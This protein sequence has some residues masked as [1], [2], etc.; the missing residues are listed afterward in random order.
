M[1]NPSIDTGQPALAQDV[2]GRRARTQGLRTVAAYGGAVLMTPYLLI[3]IFW[4]VGAVLG[5]VTPSDGMSLTGWLTLNLATIVMAAAGIALALALAEFRGF[6][7]PAF[8]VLAFAWISC[9][10]LV[11]MLP[12]LA[13]S[14]ALAGHST[15]QSA[16]TTS[17]AAPGWEMILIQ[18]SFAGLGLGLAIALPLYLLNRWPRA[19]LGRL[20]E[21]AGSPRR[22]G[23]VATVAMG[24]AAAVGA[25][26]C[27]WAAGGRF[28]LAH[29]DSRELGWHL[30][31]SN[32]AFWALLGAA[33]VWTLTQY[34]SRRLPLWI[35]MTLTWMTSGFLVAWSAWRLPFVIYLA[36]AGFP[37]G[38]VWPEQLGLEAG[39]CLLSIMA[40]T[41][42]LLT[43][44]RC[45]QSRA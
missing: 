35:P 3:K 11:P 27:Y 1:T 7:L 13:V 9:G 40:G 26:Q 24:A 22:P 17:T 30:L 25:V 16:E 10:F 19:L 38:D 15:G 29:P 8:V 36:S 45:Y 32:S 31:I 2:P 23:G 4:V 28:G 34:R 18:L 12:F 37:D 42:M 6:R 21:T 39:L 41:A 33:S 20:N 5:I 14:S 44:I 43:L